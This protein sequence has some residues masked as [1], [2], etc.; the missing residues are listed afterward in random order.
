VWSAGCEGDHQPAMA[1]TWLAGLYLAS[2][3]T[4]FGG[5]AAWKAAAGDRDVG[6][7]WISRPLRQGFRRG[8]DWRS[9]ILS[10]SHEIPTVLMIGS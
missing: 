9:Q 6:T 2:P 1:V 8:P 4:G 10:D 7:A 3:V 5:L